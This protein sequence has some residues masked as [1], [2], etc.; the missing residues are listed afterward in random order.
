MDVALTGIEKATGFVDVDVDV[1]VD[2]E[3]DVDVIVDDEDD[4]DED[5]DFKAVQN[6]ARYFEYPSDWKITFQS[7]CDNSEK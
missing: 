5:D 4:D 3:V 1:D 7:G 6:D 2:V